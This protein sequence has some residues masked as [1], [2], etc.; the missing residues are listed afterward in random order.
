MYIRLLLVSLLVLLIL[1]ALLF[2]R[3]E[4]GSLPL[5][6]TAFDLLHFVSFLFLSYL[7]SAYISAKRLVVALIALA[8]AAELLQ[9]LVGRNAAMLDL[10]LGIWGA[11][12]GYLYQSRIRYAQI[13]A[14]TSIALFSFSAI[15]ILYPQVNSLFYKDQFG[16]FDI[17][18]SIAGWRNIDASVAYPVE[19]K[20]HNDEEKWL[21][22]GRSLDY[23]W[24][25]A[26]YD[27]PLPYFYKE[28]AELSF[29]FYSEHSAFEL[30]IKLT[31]IF[32]DS[33]IL[34]ENIDQV[35]WNKISI[36]LTKYASLSSYYIKTLSIYYDSDLGLD[37]YYLD[38]VIIQ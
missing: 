8:A 6:K 12:T 4:L 10:L 2:P 20:Y 21:L 16:D 30:D 17:R 9:P 34:T 35:G 27:W 37:Y 29:S 14:L 26:S 24:S 11:L 19:L 22:K 25:G 36:P 38:K 3:Q 18:E 13:M 23:P 1:L 31:S 33:M 28:G 32:G 7:L 15:F 5:I